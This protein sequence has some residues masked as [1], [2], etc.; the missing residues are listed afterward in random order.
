MMH[1][2]AGIVYL[3]CA[4]LN[5]TGAIAAIATALIASGKKPKP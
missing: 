4:A 1:L 5:V 3:V 2:I